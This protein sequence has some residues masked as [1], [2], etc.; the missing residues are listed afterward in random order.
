MKISG[1]E[2]QLWCGGKFN[3]VEDAVPLQAEKLLKTLCILEEKDRDV[4]F[5]LVGYEPETAEIA[6]IGLNPAYTQLNN[7]CEHYV[8]TSDFN[9][10]RKLSAF[11]NK[12]LRGN[13]IKMLDYLMVGRLVGLD[14]S[15]FFFSE[16][17]R[18]KVLM[19]SVV[20]CASLNKNV[21]KRSSDW[22]ILKYSF[23]VKCASNRLL[24]DLRSARGLKAVF[25]LGD[26]AT[27]AMK[28]IRIS[29]K[30][31]YDAVDSQIAPIIELPHPSGANNENVLIFVEEKNE[32]LVRQKNRYMNCV[33]LRRRAQQVIEK[34]L[35]NKLS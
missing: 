16:Q 33:E 15:A 29:D 26:K 13:L 19:T 9:E 17:G 23:A 27:S 8:R 34:C 12:A 14:S 32:S 20:K 7:F 28:S 35:F 30:S 4:Y 11:S 31:L 2:C 6:I 18:A 5:S 24:Y 21:S 3:Q 22:D 25:V 10:S 1:K